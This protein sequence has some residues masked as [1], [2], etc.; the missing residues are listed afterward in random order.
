M[1]LNEFVNKIFLRF[2]PEIR[3]N[4][5][6][7]NRIL[8]YTM[9]LDTG[10]E[11]NYEKAYIDLLRNYSYKTTP[12]EKIV[13]EILQQNEIKTPMPKSKAIEWEN[14]L[15]DIKGITYEFALNCSFGEAR[16]ILEG[17][18]FTNVRYPEP[19]TRSY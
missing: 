9:A 11:Y 5:T 17:K 19:I 14:I 16:T 7:E 4:D 18:G 10:K 12:P 15:A 1:Q 6:L 2:P 13:L 8:D 3:G